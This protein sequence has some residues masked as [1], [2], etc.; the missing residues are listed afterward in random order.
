MTGGIGNV[1]PVRSV[2][3]RIPEINLI[4]RDNLVS[5][6]RIMSG[7]KVWI[8]NNKEK[9]NDDFP[10]LTSQQFYSKCMI[11]WKKLDESERAKWKKEISKVNKGEV[12]EKLCAECGECPG[13]YKCVGCGESYCGNMEH[14]GCWRFQRI[15]WS[16]GKSEKE[17]SEIEKKYPDGVC[18]N[19]VKS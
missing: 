3:C 15:I 4:F 12:K 19:C 5:E 10:G 7:I 11:M 6:S 18:K 8:Q 2:E 9:I 13:A 16:K 17:I 1:K 14:N